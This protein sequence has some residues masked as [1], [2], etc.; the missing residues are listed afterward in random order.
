MNQEAQN[1]NTGKRKYKRH[2]WIEHIRQWQK[3]GLKQSVYCRELNLNPKLFSLYKNKL[4]KDKEDK[5]IKIP[6]QVIN[7]NT[8]S[9]NYEIILPGNIRIK[10]NNNFES[11]S[12]KNLI[13]TL[14]QL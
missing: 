3:S 5:F 2:D 11:K 13:R 6:Q 8:A 1:K 14:I 12:L 4:K 10:I 7:S 9:N